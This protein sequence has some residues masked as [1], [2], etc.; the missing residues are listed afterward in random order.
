MK[1]RTPR[2]VALYSGPTYEGREALWSEDG[3]I[4]YIKASA[5]EKRER[6]LLRRAEFAQALLMQVQDKVDSSWRPLL[7]SYLE[8]PDNVVP[9]DLLAKFAAFAATKE[10]KSE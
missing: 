2:K 4:A 8:D 9:D 3:E 10:E 7:D 1:P 5:V 6:T